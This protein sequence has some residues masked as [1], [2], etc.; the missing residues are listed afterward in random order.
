MKSKK[1][2]T[3]QNYL[4][5]VPC[6]V[7]TYKWEQDEKGDVTIFVENKGA[8]NRI[9]QKFFKKPEVSQ[10]HLQGIGNYIWPLI[11][12]KTSIYNLGVKVKER[13][14][15]EAEPLYER[16]SEYISMLEQYGFV[17]LKK[18]W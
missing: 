3:S 10:I 7:E 11:D 5:F 12:G 13:F 2:N 9:A 18:E 1:N 6:R 15:D 17:T 16:L 8:F 4:D 14:G